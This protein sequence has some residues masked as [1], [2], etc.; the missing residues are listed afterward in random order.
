MK[1]RLSILVLMLAASGLNGCTKD[2]AA[3]APQTDGTEIAQT[4]YLEDPA[5]PDGAG[6]DTRTAVNP[7]GTI[8][9]DA[10]ENMTAH[11]WALVDGVK[12]KSANGEKATRT[13]GTPST[14]SVTHPAVTDATEYNYIFVSPSTNGAK[15]DETEFNT[16]IVHLK[17][18]QA[19]TVAS[20][21]AAQDVLVS[22]QVTA[23]PN[24]DTQAQIE[25][26]Q[27]RRL[28]TFFKLTLDRSV[29]TEIPAGEKILSVTVTANDPAVTLTG[30]ATVPVTD[31][32]ALCV[33]AFTTSSNRVSANY[34]DGAD[35]TNDKLD[36]WMVV[37][38]TSF[39]GMQ[40]KIRTTNKVITQTL[41]SFACE[42]RA[43]AI[44]TL[45]FQWVD[46]GKV[47]TTIADY[48]DY[49]TTGVT[50]NGET[51][52]STTA[53]AQVLAP[54]AT[55]VPGN[56]GVFFLDKSAATPSKAI[57]IVND[58][59]LIGRYS[60]EPVSVPFQANWVLRN[61]TGKLLFKNL[62]IDFTALTNYGFNL[63]TNG[64]NV[65]GMKTLCFEDCTITLSKPLVT[66][67]GAAQ[68]VGIE[69]IIFRNCKLR[70]EGTANST[71]ITTSKT[72]QT[73]LDVFKT[74]VLENNIIYATNN[75]SATLIYSLFCQETAGT[76]GS[77]SNLA[78]TCNNNTFVNITGFGSGRTGAFFTADK[79]G[80]VTFSKNILYS[81]HQ[82]KYPAVVAI[83]YDYNTNTPWPSIDLQRNEN[84]AFNTQGW[85]L[86]NDATG[87]YTP[88][89][90]TQKT[91]VKNLS[92]P[93]TI[94]DI[95][96]GKFVVDAAY[97]GYGSTLE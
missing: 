94:C 63:T 47:S 12:T 87:M 52:D 2:D 82:Q 83:F 95:Q 89:D 17:E 44:N 70:Y 73:G 86:F 59:A 76:T 9:F 21:D 41:D 33:P 68:T 35:F 7:D 42:L 88:S 6:P 77:L 40:I 84:K 11:I 67:Y 85:K 96:N 19:P 3:S 79:I 91:Y 69:N 66:F 29:L 28:F 14:V 36:V 97:A 43:N 61:A 92:S 25:T 18:A 75:S 31:D 78:I 23:T 1:N 32:P 58:L 5:Q 57:G 49:Y 22:K 56:G 37:N 51:Y 90:L 16:L 60:D 55:L 65:G 38:P 81:E 4:F 45:A 50:V 39:T 26:V 30:D 54:G 62:D 93:F 24:A 64:A 10:S 27:F 46:N 20:F 8:G 80:S 13:A 34:A 71:L 53:D 15:I 72:T 74:L 48:T